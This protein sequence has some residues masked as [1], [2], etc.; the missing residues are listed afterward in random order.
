MQTIKINGKITLEEKETLLHY[1]PITKVW[2]MDSTIPKHFRK[3]LKQGWNPERQYIDEDGMVC[4]MV[5]TG[6]ERAIT[7]RNVDKKK[8]SEKQLNNLTSSDE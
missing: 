7:I 3:T 2:T 4:G 6:P 1:D 5:L 8:M